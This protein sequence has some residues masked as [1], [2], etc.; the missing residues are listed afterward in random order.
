LALV[1][2]GIQ[3]VR[4]PDHVQDLHDMLFEFDFDVTQAALINPTTCVTT[5]QCIS[6]DNRKMASIVNLKEENPF[7]L[8]KRFLKYYKKGFRF[9]NT[10]WEV[11][12]ERYARLTTQ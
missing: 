3:V 12:F 5:H 1:P 2:H 6:A 7:K 8:L 4:T 9:S 10:D 11:L